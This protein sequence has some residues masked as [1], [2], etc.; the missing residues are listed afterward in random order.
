MK[1]QNNIKSF[2][3]KDFL[4][5]LTIITLFL[6]ACAPSAADP[7]DGIQEA[8]PT[9]IPLEQPTLTPEATQN[10]YGDWNE[11]INEGINF[12]VLYPSSWYGPEVYESEG[13]LRLE[14]GSDVVYPYGTDRTEQI[15]TVPDSFYITVQYFENIQG[16]TWDD[17]V[18]S[19]WID[20]FLE[21]QG[22]NDGAFVTT[23]RSLTT[24]VGEATIGSFSGL[25]YLA[26]LP[27]GAQTERVYLREI[28]AFDED[29]NWLRITGYPNNVQIM[30][31]AD[32]K[33]DYARVDQ[34]N[35][36]TFITFAESIIIGSE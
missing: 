18:A 32:W 7:G 30:D 33:N 1:R 4:P 29:L 11:F 22:Q 14:I 23:P 26:T 36:E 21:L 15:T 19:G 2:G 3:I 16:R 13:S 6:G 9:E 20:S 24:R 28:M 17:Y 5:L 8:P 10:P 35:L 25:M 12:R 27:E 31:E 34:E